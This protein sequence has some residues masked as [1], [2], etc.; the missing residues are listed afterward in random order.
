MRNQ[1]LVIFGISVWAI[2]VTGCENSGP[3][4]DFERMVNQ[5]HLLPYQACEFFS[6]HRAMRQPPA[7]TAPA[8]SAIWP[9]ALEEGSVDEN[10][11]E[12][13]PVLVTKTFVQAGRRQY[14]VFCAPCHG[15]KGDGSSVVAQ[16]MTL[17]RPPSLISARIRKYPDGRI[18]RVI[19]Q[20]HGLM[21]RYAQELEVLDRWAI[22]AYVRAL[23][24]HALGVALDEL[25]QPL[26]GQVE[27][28]LP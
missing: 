2:Y 8:D 3:S 16:K 15:L 26:R 6:D 11:I 7:A 1:R 28:V 14:G 20:G 12:T 25:P 19:T 5:A 27:E 13:N 9:S 17:R 4:R 24:V 21:P 23:G 18:F 22:V 10:Y